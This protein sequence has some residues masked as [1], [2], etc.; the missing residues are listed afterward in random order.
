MQWNSF[1]FFIINEEPF[2]QLNTNIFE[3]NLI[4]ILI[5]LGILIYANKISFSKSLGERQSEIIK[6]IENAQKDVVTASNY[7]YQ[8]EKGF[9]QSLFWLQ[10]WKVFYEAE[11]IDLVTKKY[12]FVKKALQETFLTTE[13][14]IQNIEK[15]A[16][17]TLQR[18][19][20]YVTVSKILRKFFLL[21]ENEQSKL[22]EVTIRKLGGFKK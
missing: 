11:K 19:I 6:V 13:N 16:F 21:S 7:Y 10:S 22:I 3:T 1:S 12:N 9:T 5:L 14:L 18:Y 4:N 8:A 15:K 20:I 2:I 17:L